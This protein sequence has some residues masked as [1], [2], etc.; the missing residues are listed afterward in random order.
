MSET[1]VAKLLGVVAATGLPSRLHAVKAAPEVEADF[2]NAALRQRMAG[3][4]LAAHADGRIQL[5]EASLS[6]LLQRNEAQLALDLQ[7]ERLLIIA[8]TVLEKAHIPYRALKGPVL[9]HTTYTDPALRSFGDIDLLVSPM[10][11]DAATDAFR[12]LG[13]VRR[14]VEPRTG[15]D[16]R[17][18]KGACLLGRDGFEIDLHRTLAPGAFGVRV[19]RHDFFGAPARNFALGAVPI[20]G[21]NG[22][23]AFLHA[24]FHAALGDNPPR[25]VPVR[26]VVE[27]FRIG[28]D[29][30]AVIDIAQAVSCGAVVQ[31]AVSLADELLGVALEGVL[32][33]WAR[34]YRPSAFD[35][36]ALRGYTAENRSYSR[37]VAASFCVLPTLRDRA[38]FA[39]SLA[40]PTKSYVR[41][42]EGTYANRLGH[43]IRLLREG[44]RQ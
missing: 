21:L 5:Q 20:A 40:F 11:F 29:D 42:R 8:A 38:S 26:D 6:E 30:E 18:T 4:A 2:V 37:Q 14:F 13:F 36:W 32:P 39:A 35:R 44:V 24:C 25:F 3:V 23:L 16:A 17:F 9:A 1:R 28:I 41:A 15:F 33:D 10:T 34:S 27:C 7:L 43:G 31:R 19:A 22:D 12:D